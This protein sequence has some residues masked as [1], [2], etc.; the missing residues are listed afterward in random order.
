MLPWLTD[1]K[2]TSRTNFARGLVSTSVMGMREKWTIRANADEFCTKC[3]SISQKRGNPVTLRWLLWGRLILMDEMPVMDVSQQELTCGSNGNLC[4]AVSQRNIR[5]RVGNKMRRFDL[6][7]CFSD[8]HSRRRCLE[9]SLTATLINRASHS[10]GFAKFTSGFEPTLMRDDELKFKGM[11]KN[12]G[13]WW[14]INFR[15]TV[16]IDSAL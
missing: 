8:T 6:F 7:P 15:G 13:K 5:N 3:G 14:W 16:V 12:G 1:P 4:E 11:A 2:R 9:Q 10:S